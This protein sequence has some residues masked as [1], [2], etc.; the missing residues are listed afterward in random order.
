MIREKQRR[1]SPVFVRTIQTTVVYWKNRT[2]ELDSEG[3][4]ALDNERQNLFQAVQFGVQLEETLFETAEIAWQLRYFI[5]QLGY[6][7]DWVP[8][9]EQFIQ[10]CQDAHPHLKFKLLICYGEHQRIMG[11]LQEAMNFHEEALKLATQLKHRQLLA[12]ATCA[13]G[14]TLLLKRDYRTAGEFCTEALALFK[15]TGQNHDW[16]ATTLHALGIVALGDKRYEESISLL[17]ESVQLRRRLNKRQP[18]ARALV[19]LGNSYRDNQQFNRAIHCYEESIELLE[20]TCYARDKLMAL[21][22]LGLLLFLQAEWDEA[23]IIFDKAYRLI[24][25]RPTD[26]VYLAVLVNN[27]GNVTFKLERWDEA[28]YFL[29][30]AVEIRRTQVNSPVALANSIGTLGDV[31]AAKGDSED[32]LQLYAEALA[33]LAQHQ[34]DSWAQE[35]LKEFEQKKEVL[36]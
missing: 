19:A 13:V 18:L 9:F 21:I 11:R 14:E 17:E 28:E 24:L 20:A 33:I 29:Q 6:W 5:S 34:A 15:Q 26:I 35:L 25:Q 31:L 7:S 23:Y 16:L 36:Q 4:V 32:A 30:K 1:P 2:S 8:L 22:N 3:M 12:Q 27:L 10:A